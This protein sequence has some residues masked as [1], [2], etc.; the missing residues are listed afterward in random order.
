MLPRSPIQITVLC[1]TF[2]RTSLSQ[3][4]QFPCICTF[5]LFLVTEITSWRTDWQ[6]PRTSYIAGEAN[7]A[8]SQRRQ[9]MQLHGPTALSPGKLNAMLLS[10]SG[11]DDEGTNPFTRR[12]S[13]PI[14][15]HNT[16]PLPLNNQ[17]T[18]RNR[19]SSEPES[20]SVNQEIPHISWNLKFHYRVHKRPLPVPILTV[21]ECSKEVFTHK[22]LL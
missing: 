13:N 9:E 14:R 17:P 18:Q 3:K 11:R 8:I 7:T 1:V 6:L 4:G 16:T 21:P 5:P 19:V 10:W 20:S 2:Y 12:E 15:P 22:F